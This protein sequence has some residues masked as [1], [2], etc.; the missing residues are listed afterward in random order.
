MQ[1]SIA[2][3]NPR[4]GNL[5]A[6]TAATVWGTLG[7][8]AKVIYRHNIDP[9]V[10]VTMRAGIAFSVL[11]AIVLFRSPDLL[12]VERRDLID[13]A[14]VGIV[15]IALEYWVYF[16]TLKRTSSSVAS[17]LLY[18]APVFVT[19]GAAAFFGEKITR[20]GLAA[21]G[22]VLI[23]GFLVAGGLE[24]RV[25]AQDRAGVLFGLASALTYAGYTL[26][27]KRTLPKYGSW[28]T[29][30]YAFGFGTVLLA[31]LSGPKLAQLRAVP[32][33]G[34]MLML[35]LAL[36]PTLLSYG[37]YVM[38]LEHIEASR[39]TVICMMEPVTASI[40]GFL[41]LGERL[42]GW[43]LVGALLVLGGVGFLSIRTIPST[44]KDAIRAEGSR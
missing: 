13:F 9:L 14:Y 18:T 41:L 35:G 8:F 4:Y 24:A 30:L 40:L 17:I 10:L 2:T 29:V 23:G 21:L 36:G 16:E 42:A 28:T 32:F 26:L 6:L 38:S 43:Q 31:L 15:G 33:E 25:L 11:F 44:S 39:A 22:V 7:V 27:S 1:R 3:A 12:K 5:M 19:A 37:L 34:W 20:R